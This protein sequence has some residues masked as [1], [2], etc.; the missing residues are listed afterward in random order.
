MASFFFR[1]LGNNVEEKKKHFFPTHVCPSYIYLRT[2][3]GG[4]LLC[5]H[6]E[7][8]SSFVNQ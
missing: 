6:R 2:G 4:G 7:P 1:S 5:Q 3:V 8:L